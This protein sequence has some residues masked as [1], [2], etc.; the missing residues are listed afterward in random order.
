MA[1]YSKLIALI[2][3]IKNADSFGEWAGG[4]LQADGVRG[5]G[6]QTDDNRGDGAQADGI[7]SDGTQPDSVREMPYISYNEIVHH[8]LDA[9][10]S[11]RGN[12]RGDR[13]R[14][15]IETCSLP[16]DTNIF[17]YD[18]THA[19]EQCILALLDTAFRQERFCEGTVLKALKEGY[20]LRWLERLVELTES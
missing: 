18:I 6:A 1:D 3:E 13:F 20:V 4:D 8:L 19:D 5:D 14:N 7:R 2:D 10:E 17:S 9:M 11:C 15:N 16:W 12:H